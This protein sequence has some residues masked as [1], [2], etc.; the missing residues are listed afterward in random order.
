MLPPP[1]LSSCS[2]ATAGERQ[3]GPG[4]GGRLRGKVLGMAADPHLGPAFLCNPHC[5][6][7][8]PVVSAAAPAFRSSPCASN[9]LPG[10]HPIPVRRGQYAVLR[11]L[12]LGGCVAAVF[13][14]SL[15]QFLAAGQ[16]PQVHTPLRVLLAGQPPL[17]GEV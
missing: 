13:A 8:S 2:A 3:A 7:L 1:F 14:A 10:F 16:L 17:P 9:P 6:P 12:G 4:G 11:F 5:L 15:G